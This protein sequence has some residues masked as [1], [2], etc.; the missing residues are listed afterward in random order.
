MTEA[1]RKGTK[2][3][4][5]IVLAVSGITALAQVYAPLY[6]AP[7]VPVAAPAVPTT[8]DAQQLDQLLA[9]IAL[10]PDPLLSQILAASTYPQDVSAAEQWLQYFPNPTEDNINAQPWDSSVKALVHYPTVLEMLNSQPDWIAALGQAFATQPQDVMNSVQRLRAKAVA[11]GTLVNT[12]Q[13]DIVNDGGMIEIL[14]AAPQTI[15]VPEYDPDIVYAPPAGYTEPWITFGVGFVV[16]PWFD[17]DC[18]WHHYRFERGVRFDRDWRH[19]DFDHVQEWRHNPGR[20]IPHPRIIPDRPHGIV[21]GRG[22][23]HPTRPPGIFHP[24]EREPQDHH[25][26]E[27]PV[28]GIPAHNEPPPHVAVP[29]PH[30]VRPEP[31]PRPV[32]RPIAPQAPP[33]RERPVQGLPHSE[34][35]PHQQAPQQPARNAPSASPPPAFHGGGGGAGIQGARGGGSMGHR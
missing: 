12:P 27:R 9:P 26:P 19:P 10:Y 1:S 20:P 23:D 25:V 31:M 8:L 16:G 4:A 6:T 29:T 7:P 24:G 2:K 3:I 18:D 21:P 35:A 32:Q 17:L 5:V 33:V 22:W 34:P 30:P 11:A 15:Y 14:P 13:Q 28:N